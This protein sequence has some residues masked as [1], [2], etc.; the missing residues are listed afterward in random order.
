M[1]GDEFWLGGIPSGQCG[2][3]VT[4]VWWVLGLVS[5]AAN[6]VLDPG[7]CLFFS[8]DHLHDQTPFGLVLEGPLNPLEY[9]H[10][11]RV[12]SFCFSD[13]LIVGLRLR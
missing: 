6:P 9:W 3:M 1:T 11:V 5:D 13:Y 7:I 12:S 2:E 10:S 4:G 8:Q